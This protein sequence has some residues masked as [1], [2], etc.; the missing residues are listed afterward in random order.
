MSLAGC[1]CDDD[2]DVGRRSFQT[3][4]TAIIPTQRILRPWGGTAKFPTEH[5]LHGA[6]TLLCL[7]MEDKP[8][9]NC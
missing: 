1:L 6:L 2:D 9:F 3:L 8:T 5:R 7:K 4:M